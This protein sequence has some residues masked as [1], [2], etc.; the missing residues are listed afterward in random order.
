[1]KKTSIISLLLIISITL[2]Y[3]SSSAKAR[4]T[5]KMEVSKSTYT[6]T[7]TTVIMANC[8]PCHIP[9]KGGNKRPYDTYG[10]VRSDIDEILRR[11]QLNPGE[12]GFMP[13]KKTSRLSD[14]TIAVFK[15]WK[16]DG[17]VE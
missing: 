2:T 17:L 15:K 4:R 12:R 11:I 6:S 5:A 13:M 9:S 16:D 10:N 7:I 8:V 3:C 1:M 14:S